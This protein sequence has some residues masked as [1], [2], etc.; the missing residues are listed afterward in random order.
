MTMISTTLTSLALGAIRL[1]QRFISPY[2]GFCCAYCAYT[3]NASCSALGYRAVRRFGVWEGIGILRQRLGKCSIAHRRYR[4]RAAQRR[5]A[6][7]AGF[8]DCDPGCDL[9]CDT[10]GKWDWTD[11]MPDNCHSNDNKKNRKQRRA[12]RQTHI[13]PRR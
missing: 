1:Y 11:C 3:G 12:E 5:L 2:K 10:A 4:P 7:Q 6:R 9:P 8:C 13:P